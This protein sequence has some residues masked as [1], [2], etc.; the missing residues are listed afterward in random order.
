MLFQ[1]L[2]N[3]ILLAGQGAG[4][5]NL[6]V[7][8]FWKPAYMPEYLT[9]R[10]AVAGV[11][12]IQ[13]QNMLACPNTL[14]HNQETDR[15]GLDPA[16][17]VYDSIVDERALHEVYLHAFKAVVQEANVA[18]VMCSYN[19]VNGT[20]TCE[21]P[22]LLNILKEDWGF[23]DLVVSDWFFATRSTVGSVLGG[24][25]IS[26]PGG[27][28]ESTYGFPAYC[29]DLLVEAVSNGSVPFSRIDDMVERLWR[30]MFQHGVIEKHDWQYESFRSNAH[31]DLA[32]Q[33]AEQGTVLLKNDGEVLP[34]VATKYAKI[35]IFV[36]MQP[37]RPNA[38]NME[39]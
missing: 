29:G 9:A 36:L 39:K 30:P 4:C 6:G 18:S 32:Q 26:M 38:T 22:W 35:A 31:L 33:M 12:G 17:N 1:N 25:D 11:L 3:R 16:W 23:K 13:S 8:V 5:D 21:D 2:L 10:M 14:Q 20:Y 27:N 15:F 34:L 37:I 28:L 7:C 24:L 19:K